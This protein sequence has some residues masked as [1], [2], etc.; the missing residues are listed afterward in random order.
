MPDEVIEECRILNAWTYIQRRSHFV[1][2]FNSASG[3]EW[4]E[5]VDSVSSEYLYWHEDSNTHQWLKPEL[6]KVESE[7]DKVIYK[8]DDNVMFRF[9]VTGKTLGHYH[10][11]S[12]DDETNELCMTFVG[13]KSILTK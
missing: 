2:E 5:Y 10:Q 11:N 13:Q 4:E 8:V 7:I 9:P 3:E 1:G 12:L 6:S